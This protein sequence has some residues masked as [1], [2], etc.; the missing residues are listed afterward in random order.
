VTSDLALKV[1]VGTPIY[2][3]QVHSEFCAALLR[4]GEGL[5]R[6][7]VE[8]TWLTSVGPSARAGRNMIV[9]K[10]LADPTLSHVMWVDADVTWLPDAI[11]R[12]LSHDLDVV[13][14]L[15]PVKEPPDNRLAVVALTYPRDIGGRRRP[16]PPSGCSPPQGRCPRCR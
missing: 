16:S 11:L 9:A 1:A 4:A 10:F 15:Y 8:M 2:G 3:W 7:G 6:L 13:A 14:G 5:R 12:L